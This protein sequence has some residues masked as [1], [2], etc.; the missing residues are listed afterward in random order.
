VRVL[1]TGGA[2][3]IG[4]HTMLSNGVFDYHEVSITNGATIKNIM[5]D[6]RPEAVIHFAG[7]KAVGESDEKPLT[8]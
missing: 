8:Y 6:F 5:A 1:V 2:G 4:S 3:Y 7:L